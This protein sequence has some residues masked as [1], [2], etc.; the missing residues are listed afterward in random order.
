[1]GEIGSAV[2]LDAAPADGGP[3]TMADMSG[4]LLEVTQLPTP[5]PVVRTTLRRKLVVSDVLLV[6]AAW[7]LA[8]VAPWAPAGL[9][10]S[11][12]LVA[13]GF[14]AATVLGLH[15]AGLHR[16]RVCSVRSTEVI[17]LAYVSAVIGIVALA[18]GDLVDE[19]VGSTAL[20][21]TAMAFLALFA[22]RAVF[23][24]WL[25]AQRAAGR[26]LR[27]VAIVGAD[28]EASRLGAHLEDHPEVGYSVVGFFRSS[29]GHA[30]HLARPMLGQAVDAP[31]ILRKL[32]VNGVIVVPGA[33]LQSERDAVL[34]D[35]VE[36]KIHVHLATGLRG[37]DSRRLRSLPLGHE[38]LLYLEPPGMHAPWYAHLKRLIDLVVG[39]LA[40]IL[41]APLLALAALAIKLTD[42]GPVL[43]RQERV[44][45]ANRH[46][47]IYKLRSMTVDAEERLAELKEQAN[48]R[49]GGPL[50]KLDNDPRVTKVGAFL[51]ATSF[52][53][54]PQLFNVLRGEMS[55]VG[56]RPALPDEVALFD[57]ELLVR[58]QVRPG[59]TGLWQVEARD[60][61]AFSAYRYLDVFYVENQSLALDLTILMATARTVAGSCLRALRHRP[62]PE[63]PAAGTA[64]VEV[65]MT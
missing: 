65:V 18:G 41:V 24:D 8:P 11:W 25:L 36:S 34:A 4:D 28:E 22:G 43:F 59:V 45:M 46:F 35:L 57:D 50:F 1:M 15:L 7:L 52:D 14:T 37:I 44:G 9:P 17:R 5:A 62:R 64:D 40:L 26:L 3:E 29:Q 19:G 55:L 53:E 31:A 10:I 47:W 23:R 32:Q 42:G 16:G 48:Q 60:K 20:S 63:V 2:R 27:S 6:L 12:L 21:A 39:S 30:A 33:L 38:P 51:R 61:P 56:P 58:Q 49:E 13:G 54:I